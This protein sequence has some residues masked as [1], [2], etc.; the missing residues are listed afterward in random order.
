ME[1]AGWCN[2]PM[3]Q[4]KNVVH[5]NTSS[6]G[7]ESELQVK[8]EPGFS[9]I[10]QGASQTPTGTGTGWASAHRQHAAQHHKQHDDRFGDD[11]REGAPADIEHAPEIGLDSD[12]GNR[13]DQEIM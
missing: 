1:K 6:N 11:Q 8:E 3:R 9:A 13:D 10:R 4:R 5:S 12:R 2:L 7:Q